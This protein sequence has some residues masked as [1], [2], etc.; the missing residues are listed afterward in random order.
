MKPF[1]K[2]EFKT[3]NQEIFFIYKKFLIKQFTKLN[4]YYSHFTLPIKR[5]KITLL[6]SPHVY[7][8]SREQ[9]ELKKYKHLIHIYSNCPNSFLKFLIINKPFE[10]N[11]TLKK[12]A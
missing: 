6:R 3:L 7:K 10:I 2:L 8:K 5:K 4:I 9:F 1:L 12:I 11:L